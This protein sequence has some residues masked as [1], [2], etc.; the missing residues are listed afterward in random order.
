MHPI[1]CESWV[2]FRLPEVWPLRPWMLAA[3][4]CCSC[5]QRN[6]TVPLLVSMERSID[7]RWPGRK[8]L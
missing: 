1:S 8:L 4:S 3:S 7:H 2:G 6:R 5:P